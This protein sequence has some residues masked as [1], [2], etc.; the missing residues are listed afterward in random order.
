[1]DSL[2]D[3]IPFI[4]LPMVA[5]L[6][7]GAYLRIERAARRE[8]DWFASIK[9]RP[10]DLTPGPVQ[11]AVE[12]PSG[13]AIN[14]GCSDEPAG[15]SG[16]PT[17]R[18]DAVRL[19]IVDGALI[20]VVAGVPLRVQSVAGAT[21]T[22]VKS[23]TTGAGIENRYTFELP[24][25]KRFWIR[26]VLRANAIPSHDAYRDAPVQA[27]DPLGGK[28]M[29]SDAED[30]VA[31]ADL[32]GYVLGRVRSLAF[33]SFA[34][35]VVGSLIAAAPLTAC[36]SGH[37]HIQFSEVPWLDSVAIGAVVGALLMLVV[38]GGRDDLRQTIGH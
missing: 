36:T 18:T 2:R 8:R 38:A 9:R 33:G 28:L 30:G 12:I 21:R 10:G 35:G 3:A 24:P 25:G 1:M 17:L 14:L 27:L 31:Y 22:L 23:V 6:V 19:T 7:V 34:S 13:V 16:S 15:P 32:S 20:D 11:L 37:S 29:I 5:V 4:A 26:G